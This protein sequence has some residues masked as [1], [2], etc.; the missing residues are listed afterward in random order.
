MKKCNY[1]CGKNVVY[2]LFHTN[3]RYCLFVDN[4]SLYFSVCEEASRPQGLR[5][6]N[7]SH[8]VLVRGKI[9]I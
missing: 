4:Y 8:A 5:L 6:H 7:S 2:V 1:I 9:V 3:C